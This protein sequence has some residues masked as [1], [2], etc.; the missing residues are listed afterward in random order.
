M[1]HKT[2]IKLNSGAG[3]PALGLGKFFLFNHRGTYLKLPIGELALT[4]STLKGPGNLRM[5]MLPQPYSM[6]SNRAIGTSIVLSV[7]RM[8]T[9]LVRDSPRPLNLASASGKMFL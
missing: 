3:M 6:R 7:I 1:A 5:V 8:K 2:L 9:K 4:H